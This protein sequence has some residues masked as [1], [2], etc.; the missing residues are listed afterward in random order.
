MGESDEKNNFLYS[1]L[2]LDGVHPTLTLPAC[3]ESAPSAGGVLLYLTQMK[4][5]V[6][7]RRASLFP[8]GGVAK[9]RE[10]T[11]N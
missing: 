4:S 5:A 3:G 7:R 1:P 8:E 10:K 9:T 11:N 6:D 2:H